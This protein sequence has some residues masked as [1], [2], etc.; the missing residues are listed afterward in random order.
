MGWG[1]VLA[2]SDTCMTDPA[3]TNL[4]EQMLLLKLLPFIQRAE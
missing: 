2:A 1:C 3:E 4:L